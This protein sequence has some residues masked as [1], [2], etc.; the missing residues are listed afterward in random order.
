MYGFNPISKY[1][2]GKGHPPRVVECLAVI[3]AEVNNQQAS[4]PQR[5]VFCFRRRNEWILGMSL[6]RS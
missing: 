1:Q 3:R 4:T 6:P 5:G 2:E